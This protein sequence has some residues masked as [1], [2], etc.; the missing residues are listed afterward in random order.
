[1]PGPKA[2][3]NKPIGERKKEES[4]FLREKMKQ[5]WTCSC[6]KTYISKNGLRKHRKKTK[7]PIL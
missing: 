6:N 1:M 4:E 5:I 7:H 3:A 2:R